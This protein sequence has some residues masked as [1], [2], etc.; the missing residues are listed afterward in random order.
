MPRFPVISTIIVALAV[1]TMIGLGIWQLQRKG[2]KEALLALYAANATKPAMAFPEIG[3]V[4][5]DALFRQ[6]SATCM[7][8]SNGAANR[9]VIARASRGCSILPN[10]RQA[11]T[12]RACSRQWGLRTGPI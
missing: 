3:P 12:V 1:A 2:E 6:S 10:A 4:S 11:P 8:W 9:D 5:D 7:R